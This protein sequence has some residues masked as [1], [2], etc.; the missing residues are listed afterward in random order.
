[1]DLECRVSASWTSMP[2]RD[3]AGPDASELRLIPL[4]DASL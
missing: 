4:A 2:E 3:A 1:M